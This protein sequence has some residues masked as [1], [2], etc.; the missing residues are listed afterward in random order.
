MDLGVLA[1]DFSQ[2]LKIQLS[3]DGKTQVAYRSLKAA[4]VSQREAEDT[5]QR[6]FEK[7][8]ILNRI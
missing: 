7:E 4:E 1:G 2:T 5:F 8:T 3:P 6:G